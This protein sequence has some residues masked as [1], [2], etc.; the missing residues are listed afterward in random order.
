MRKQIASL[1]P[2]RLLDRA[3]RTAALTAVEI[4]PVAGVLALQ[5][6]DA[7]ALLARR[8]TLDVGE[9]PFVAD[10]AAVGEQPRHPD[11]RGRAQPG[12]DGVEVVADLRRKRMR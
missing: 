10:A 6:D 4:V 1:E 2:R 5:R 11:L 7:A 12:D 9:P 3:E 8:R